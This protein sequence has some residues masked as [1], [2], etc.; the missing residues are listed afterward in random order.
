MS[1]GRFWPLLSSESSSFFNPAMEN[2]GF[3][4]AEADL[5]CVVDLVQ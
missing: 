3:G 5:W 2:D 4:R 1:T